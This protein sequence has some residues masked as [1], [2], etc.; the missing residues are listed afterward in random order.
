MT[1]T[2]EVG[3]LSIVNFLRANC[4]GYKHPASLIAACY[5]F[6]NH[7]KCA[8]LHVT[9]VYAMKCAPYIEEQLNDTGGSHGKFD[10]LRVSLML[11]LVLAFMWL[12]SNGVEC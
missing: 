8:P 4:Y 3:P 1:L 5:S 6:G 12:G 9:C 2:L 11:R 10:L 7:R